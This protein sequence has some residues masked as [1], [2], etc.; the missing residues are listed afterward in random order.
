LEADVTQIDKQG[1]WVLIGDKESF[2]SFEAFPW[3]RN[4]PVSAIHHVELLN[5]SHLHWPELDIDLAV[6][7]I[8]H[9][10]LFPLIATLNE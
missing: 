2:L 9:P 7:S 10:H 8:E 1:I 3:F 4:A 6:D 5:P